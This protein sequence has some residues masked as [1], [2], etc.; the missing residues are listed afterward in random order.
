MS[1]QDLSRRAFIHSAGK[2]GVVA[3]LSGSV[4]SALANTGTTHIKQITAAPDPVPYKQRAL[5]Y[6]Y[7]ALEP[8]IDAMT[9]E[10]HYTKHAATYAKNLAEAV[11]AEKVDESKVTLEDLLASISKYSTKMRN[12]AGGHY[13]HSL[14]WELMTAPGKTVAPS[15]ALTASIQRDFGSLDAMKTKFNDAAKGRFGSGWAWIIVKKDGKLDVVSTPNQDNPLM[16]ISDAKGQPLIGLDVWEHAY[17]LKYQ[18]KR[19]DY[20]SAWWSVINWD[21]INNR[22]TMLG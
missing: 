8:A 16:D 7:A 5:P 10:I 12:N 3:G 19:P 11:E 21:Y 14:F 9:M 15:P 20:I 1:N 2:A 13:N 4:L 6:T 18:N 22:Y 17:Y